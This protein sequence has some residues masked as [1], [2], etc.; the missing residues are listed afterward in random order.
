MSHHGS[1]RFTSLCLVLTLLLPA[2]V[3][4]QD[5]PLNQNAARL[6]EIVQSYVPERFMG[7]VLVAR[8]D[9]LVLNK[10][11]GS[12]NLEWNVP[13]TPETKFRLG[14]ITKQFT[15][16]AILLLEEQGKLKTS[17]LVSAHLPSTPEAWKDITLHHL[18]SHEAG[19]PNFTNLPWYRENMMKP[20]TAQASIDV[21]KDL[22]L[23]FAPGSQFRYSNSGFIVL[24]RVIELVSGASYADFVRDNIFMPLGMT[25][26]GYDSNTQVIANRAA[27]YAPGPNGPMNAGY[28][29]MTVPHGAG[30][31]YSTTGDLLKWNQGLFG[32]ALLSAESVAK[33]TT[34]NLGD[35]A[36][37][38]GVTKAHDA[39]KVS[40]N[41]GI[42]GFNTSMTYYPDEELLIVALANINGNAPDVIVA[43]L[44]DLMHGEEIVLAAERQEITLSDD[45]L[46]KYVGTYPLSPVF[47]ISVTVENGQ[48]ITQATNQPKLPIYAESE[49]RFFP[50]L[51]E[52]TIDFQKDAQGK[53]TGLTLNQN[54][55]SSFGPKQPLVAAPPEPVEISVSEEIL[56]RYVGSYALAP[57]FILTVTLENGQLITQAT[58]Q[59]PVP[60]FAETE[61]KFFPKVVRATIEFQLDDTGKVT[62]L[63]LNQNGRSMPAP[64]Q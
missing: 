56:A 17:D 19:L 29:D 40:H 62:G 33:M 5:P 23:E 21:F 4:G 24:G 60:I 57:N 39:K 34:P 14:S 3:F 16:A 64:K 46:Q 47:A 51:V 2:A 26:S 11:Y 38:V 31:L 43:Q 37:G 41:G 8:G 30:A 27:G 49:T 13:N 63:V 22:P 42:Q 25:N 1:S 36:Y 61:T 18:L 48:L 15:A 50:K 35:Y 28:V 32:G 44:D 54:G 10:S 55:R 45:I 9:E 59:G 7:S 58:G 6:D 20:F 53:V 52:A 12:A